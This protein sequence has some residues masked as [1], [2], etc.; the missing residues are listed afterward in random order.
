MQKENV[1]RIYQPVLI[2]LGLLLI[3]IF[4]AGC[5]GGAAPTN[6]AAPTHT[7]APTEPPATATTEPTAAPTDTPEPSPTPSKAITSLDGVKRATIYIVSE[8]TFVDPQEGSMSFAGQGSGFIIDES[9]LAVTNNHVVTGAALIKVRIGGEGP[10]LNARI[11]GVSEC[12]DLAVIDI[13][14]DGYEYLEWFD[15]PITTGLDIYVA[16]FPL[17]DP[18]FTLTRGIVAKEKADGE[19]NWASVDHVIQH[20]ASTN[21]GNS[22]GPVVTADGKVVAIHYAGDP[23]VIQ[24]FAIGRDEALGIIDR[25]SAGTDVDSIGVNGEAVVGTDISGIW[26]ASVASG[27]AADNAGIK[28]GDLIL[29]MENLDLA[30]DGTM[31]S[32]CDILRTHNPGD[33]L[34]VEVLRF[35]TQ[36]VLAGQINGRP[37][38]ETASFAGG[39][40]SDSEGGEPGHAEDISPGYVNYVSI[41]DDSGAIVMDVP[42]EWNQVEGGPWVDDDGTILGASLKASPGSGD[43]NPFVYFG[44]MALGPG[45]YDPVTFLDAIDFA[46]QCS[47]YDG[48]DVYEDE[49]YTGLYDLYTDCGASGAMLYVVVAAPEDESFLT[50]VMVHAVTDAD[51]EAAQRVFDSFAVVDTLPGLESG[52]APSDMASL[53]LTNSSE[54]PIFALF[55]SPTASDNWGDDWLGNEIIQVG[56]SF[57]VTDIPIDTYDIQVRD[58]DN[59]SMGTLYSIYLKGEN[60]WTVYGVATLPDNADLRFEDDFSDNRN[61]WG[62]SGDTPQATYYPPTDG[63]FCLQ[64][65]NDHWIAWEWYE[66]FRADEFFAQT[67]CTTDN[68]YGGCSLGFGP[69]GD[70]VYWFSVVPESQEYTLALLVDDVWQEDLI[71]WTEAKSIDPTG[72]NYLALGRVGGVVTVYINGTLVGQV[73]NDMFPT[74][75]IGVGGETFDEPNVTVCLDELKV[76]Q[77]R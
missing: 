16:G 36:Q 8:G 63:E 9:G 14:G 44:A 31:A 76:W 25:L 1:M 69:D 41:S 47:G 66:P 7:T 29:S 72:G 22:G 73:A 19:T 46:D 37:L 52:V 4:I 12:S 26:V 50:L 74:G 61:N 57:V 58:A 48:R 53:E 40:E 17:G 38:V 32:Y 2:R 64:I 30:T 45:E 42:E 10:E 24:Q 13:Q 18:E 27:S 62:R 55:I 43:D 67:Y 23:S 3:F 68:P 59:T 56:D 60:T 11:L 21:P 77:L 75:R 15:G 35:D 5:G 20:D 71:D 49:L 34:N 70:N 65:K 54:N 33:T 6:T 51:R 39:D 28:G